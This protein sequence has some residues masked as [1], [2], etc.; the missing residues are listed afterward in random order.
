MVIN[1][2]QLMRVKEKDDESIL[3]NYNTLMKMVTVIGFVYQ[4]HQLSLDELELYKKW[5]EAK[6]VKN[7]D[8][9]DKL[10]SEL[11]SKGII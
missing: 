1:I 5:L 9:A 4:P 2:N 10:R 11:I 7:F 8:V 3:M 6:E